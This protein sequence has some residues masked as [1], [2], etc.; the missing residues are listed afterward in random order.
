MS[1][2]VREGL[3]MSLAEREPEAHADAVPRKPSTAAP[4]VALGLSEP[5][6]LCDTERVEVMEGEVE[7]VKLTRGE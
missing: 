3:K 5:L 7:E 6:P 4:P 2:N 1:V